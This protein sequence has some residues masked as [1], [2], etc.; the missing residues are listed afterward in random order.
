MHTQGKSL[1]AAA[2]AASGRETGTSSKAG[3]AWSPVDID[4]AH[5]V[6][7]KVKA[8][9]DNEW[10][11]AT[12]RKSPGSGPAAARADHRGR[13]DPAARSRPGPVSQA[14]GSADA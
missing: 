7:V 10:G 1:L 5:V 8:F 2:A 9:N 3:A 4:I 6:K 14:G 11:M 13:L 12:P